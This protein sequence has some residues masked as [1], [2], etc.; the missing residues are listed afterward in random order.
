MMD[1]NIYVQ[2]SLVV[3]GKRRKEPFGLT[4]F[5]LVCQEKKHFVGLRTSHPLI[6]KPRMHLYTLEQF[7][8]S[9]YDVVDVAKPRGLGFLGV[10]KASSP[11]DSDVRLLLVQL[12]G[13]G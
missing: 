12:H 13:T 2:N 5:D 7:Q 10:V 1:V 4:T 11:V 9:Q 8:N 6:K 3:S